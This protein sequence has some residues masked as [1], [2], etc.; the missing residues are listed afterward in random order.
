MAEHDPVEPKASTAQLV[1]QLGNDIGTLIRQEV[2]LAKAELSAKGKQAGAGGAMLGVAALTG[3]GALGA[4]TACLILALALV[5]PAALAALVVTLLYGGIAA[6]AALA[7]KRKVQR[8]APPVPAETVE[9]V[10]E[11][12]EWAKTQLRSVKR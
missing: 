7:G 1:K 4:L 9:T 12:I 8:A 2:Q 10:K 5:M 11:D 3:L 6:A